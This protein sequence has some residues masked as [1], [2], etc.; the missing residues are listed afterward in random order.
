MRKMVYKPMVHGLGKISTVVA[1]AQ[2]Y[3]PPHRRGQENRSRAQ[4]IAR[5]ESSPGEGGWRTGY[6][7]NSTGS[8]VT[9]EFEATKG[10]S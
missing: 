5:K 4:E 1:T 10:K 3:P 9:R 6:L 8:R 7:G 2:R